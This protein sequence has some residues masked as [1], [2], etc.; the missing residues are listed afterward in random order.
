LYELSKPNRKNATYTIMSDGYLKGVTYDIPTSKTF[1]L[2]TKTLEKNKTKYL[3]FKIMDSVNIKIG[4]IYFIDASVEQENICCQ[5]NNCKYKRKKNFISVASFRI[6]ATL[7]HNSK[8][9]RSAF[10]LLLNLQNNDFPICNIKKSIMNAKLFQE[11]NAIIWNKCT[12]AH[13]SIKSNFKI[14]QKN[15]QSYG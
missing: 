3:Y 14:H 10:K 15:N 9:A 2:Q 12:L 8:T 13:K 4:G 7:L 1:V 5:F 11:C 6:A